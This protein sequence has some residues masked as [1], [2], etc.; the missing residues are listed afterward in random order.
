MNRRRQKGKK[1][2]LFVLRG[3]RIIEDTVRVGLED[4]EGRGGGGETGDKEEGGTIEEEG[5]SRRGKRI[6]DSRTGYKRTKR[7]HQEEV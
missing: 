3:Y 5:D 6:S 7:R 4:F 1:T 2:K